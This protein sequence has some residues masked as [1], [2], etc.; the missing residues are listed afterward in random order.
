MERALAE[1]LVNALWQ[2][3]L[4][5]GGAWL[6]VRV[7]RPGPQIQHAAWLTVLGL[8]VLLPIHGMGMGAFTPQP[9]A[10]TAVLEESTASGDIPSSRKNHFFPRTRRLHLNATAAR[11]VVRMYLA[12]VALALI[13]IARACVASRSAPGG[14][15]ARDIRVQGRVGP[16][17]PAIPGDAASSARVG[18]CVESRNRG[19]ASARAAVACGLCPLYR[20]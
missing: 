9:Q 11:W 8:A 3:P 2:V 1:Y 7:V 4:L 12:T 20:R 19:C 13:R 15:F 17:Q 14:I 16:L 18:G 6:L 10:T 5:A